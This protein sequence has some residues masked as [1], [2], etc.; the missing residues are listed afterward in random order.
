MTDSETTRR[1]FFGL[2][3]GAALLC[4]IGGEQVTVDGPKGLARADALASGVPRPP[5]AQRR[6]TAFPEIQPQPGG[7]RV[8]YWI[9]A[10]SLKWDIVPTHRDKWMN[11][12]IR[13]RTT[14]RAYAYREMTEGFAA[15]KSAPSIP[16][17]TLE[18]Q[19]GDVLVVHFRNADTKL[20][21]PVT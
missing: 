15:A 20:R 21:Q 18:A 19:V 17:P 16:G 1:S 5:G 12:T 7:R 11:R 6:L 3:G 2:A 8:E 9:Q 4:T 10:E 14:Y 13:G